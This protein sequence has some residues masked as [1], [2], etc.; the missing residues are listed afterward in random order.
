MNVRKGQAWL[1]AVLVMVAGLATGACG[2][3]SQTTASPDDI[4]LECGDGT[5]ASLFDQPTRLLDAS[6]P[7][8]AAAHSPAMLEPELATQKIWR[9]REDGSTRHYFAG[10]PPNPY[11]ASI[12]LVDGEWKQRNSGHC[13]T[14]IDVSPRAI[15]LWAPT[16]D[17]DASATSF[18]V[19]VTDR[20]C[21]GGRSAEERVGEA[22]VLETDA[23]VTITFTADALSGAQSCPGHQPAK[24]TV[25]LS[26]PLGDRALLDGSLYPAQPACRKGEES[27]SDERFHCGMFR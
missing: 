19:V 20:Q 1:A 7:D 26:K 18:A 12:E 16:E 14:F 25:E 2:K 4:R 10:E 5:P 3:E 8:Q 11:H 17:V 15:A 21:A 24:R 6:E 9:V 23:S 27:Q 13:Q 22:D